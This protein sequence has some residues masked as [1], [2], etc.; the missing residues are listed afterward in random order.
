MF[1]NYTQMIEKLKDQIENNLKDLQDLQNLYIGYCS[2]D[3]LKI[4]FYVN[5]GRKIFENLKLKNPNID[6]K[7]TDITMYF[8]GWIYLSCFFE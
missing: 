8:I 7:D 6:I 4:T 5:A 1:K 3:D 2:K